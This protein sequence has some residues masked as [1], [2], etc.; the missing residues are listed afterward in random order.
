MQCQM[1]NV[2]VCV[3]VR[4]FMCVQVDYR[5]GFIKENAAIMNQPRSNISSQGEVPSLPSGLFYI[6]SLLYF[7][8][9]MSFQ[10]PPP[11]PFF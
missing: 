5:L 3:Y 2:C 10:P 6:F 9:T 8:I 7:L 11:P 1:L 4:V